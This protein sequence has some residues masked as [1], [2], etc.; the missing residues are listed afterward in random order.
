[1]SF[2][3]QYPLFYIPSFLLGLVL[4][5]FVV[6]PILNAKNHV[7][8]TKTLDGFESQEELIGLLKLRDDLLRMLLGHKPQEEKLSTLSPEDTREL[9]ETICF[10]LHNAGLT[11]LPKPEDFK[12]SLKEATK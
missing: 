10:R 6:R 1:M 3:A 12:A 7:F 9:L 11:F 4:C 5:Y 8:N 2:L